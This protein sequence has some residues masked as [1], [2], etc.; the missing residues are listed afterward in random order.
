MEPRA[1]IARIDVVGAGETM[2]VY[3]GD[4]TVWIEGRLVGNLDDPS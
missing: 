1:E 3:L 2:K 4:W